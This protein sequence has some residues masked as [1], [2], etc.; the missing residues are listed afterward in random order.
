MRL[1]PFSFHFGIAIALA[2]LLLLPACG[3]N[4]KYGID[5][6]PQGWND[7]LKMTDTLT[8]SAFCSPDDTLRMDGV[9]YGILGQFEDPIFGTTSAHLFTNLS[10]ASPIQSY[11]PEP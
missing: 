3:T 5:L 1:Y 10:V 7:S 11:G 4:E 2:A 9:E 8:V 6:I